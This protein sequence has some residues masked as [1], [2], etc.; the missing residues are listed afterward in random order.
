MSRI[1]GKGNL[2]TELRLIRLM[3]IAGITGWR[4]HHPVLGK[5]DFVFPKK[6]LA[7]FVDGCFWHMCPRCGYT[8]ANNADFWR[9]KLKG[10]RERDRI[11]TRSLRKIGWTVLR[12]WEHEMVDGDRV[13][14]KLSAVVPVSQKHSR[15]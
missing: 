12:I 9:T 14:K 15:S 4:R 8:P 6:K 2:S 10:N 3:R 13:I 5:P 1:R 7:V 11:V